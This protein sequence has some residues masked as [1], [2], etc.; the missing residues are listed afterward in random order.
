MTNAEYA[1]QS[2][3]LGK[4]YNNQH[5][6]SAAETNGNN[7]PPPSDDNRNGNGGSTDVGGKADESAGTATKSQD[8]QIIQPLNLR[9]LQ[10]AFIVLLC[11]YAAA[12]EGICNETKLLSINFSQCMSSYSSEKVF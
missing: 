4:E 10:G 12:S 7:E 3:M 2:R 8:T 6:T 11:G 9:M 1:T 5:P